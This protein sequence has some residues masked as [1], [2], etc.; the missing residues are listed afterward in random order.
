MPNP[1]PNIYNSNGVLNEKK[2][3]D[4]IIWNREDETSK[5]KD[6]TF[7]GTVGSFYPVSNQNI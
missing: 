2:C 7:L 4:R 1:T 5:F 3:T 6:N